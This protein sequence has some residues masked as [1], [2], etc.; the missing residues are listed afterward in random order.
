MKV[1]DLMHKGIE[2]MPPETPLMK[3]AKKM[4]DMDI[5]AIPI[6]SN[7]KLIG[8]VT[9]RDITV[10]AVANGKDPASLT[11]QDVMTKGVV[12]C[13]EN[14][15]L[16]DVLEVMEENKIRRVPVTDENE[17]FVG[18]V[19]LGDISAAASDK[20]ASEVLQAVAAHHSA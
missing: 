5:G 13:R 2:I 10:R 8:M 3:L 4:R 9:D 17:H 11:A 12:C 18:M 7:G 15:K 19:S 14:D 1:R 20:A 16:R 6:G